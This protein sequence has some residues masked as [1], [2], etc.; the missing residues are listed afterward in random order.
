MVAGGARTRRGGERAHGADPRN[1]LLPRAPGRRGAQP[2]RLIRSGGGGC[3]AILVRGQAIREHEVVTLRLWPERRVAHGC[4]WPTGCGSTNLHAQAHVEDPRPRRPRDRGGADRRVGRWRADRARRR[5]QPARA[6]RPAGV[7]GGGRSQCRPCAR[8][9]VGGDGA[10]AAL[11]E[12]A[13]VGSSRAGGGGGAGVG[14][15]ARGFVVRQCGGCAAFYMVVMVFA[16][17]PLAC[18]ALPPSPPWRRAPAKRP[19]TT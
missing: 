18:S 4:G 1:W 13:A 14:G 17:H 6:D 9:R 2:R 10:G 5:P 8:A 7:F 15:P 16:A 3:N 11:G 12:R 19:R